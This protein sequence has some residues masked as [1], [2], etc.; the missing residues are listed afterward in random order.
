[1]VKRI[2]ITDL[3]EGKVRICTDCRTT[4]QILGRTT[5]SKDWWCCALCVTP[6]YQVA[7][8]VIFPIGVWE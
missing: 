4:Y 3:E 7:S 8:T 2:W 1:M 5:E 6:A